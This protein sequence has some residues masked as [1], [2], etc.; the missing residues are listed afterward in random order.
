MGIVH[1]RIR[2]SDS[3][4]GLGYTRGG[5]TKVPYLT[6][7]KRPHTPLS[8]ESP[9]SPVTAPQIAVGTECTSI[10]PFP[11]PSPPPRRDRPIPATSSLNPNYK[12]KEEVW[13]SDLTFRRSWGRIPAVVVPRSPADLRCRRRSR[14][15]GGRRGERMSG[16]RSRSVFRAGA[17]GRKRG[18]GSGAP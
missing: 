1:H 3:P 5:P 11:S 14:G 4:P 8:S 10:P 13:S 18:V 17:K 2:V 7:E 16:S 15:G 6:P 9:R 12:R